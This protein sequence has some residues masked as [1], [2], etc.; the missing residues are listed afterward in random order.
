MFGE[1]VSWSLLP[2]SMWV[3]SYSPDVEKLF[4]WFGSLFQSTT[5]CVQLSI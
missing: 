5:F 3:S 1:T 2:V 4:S